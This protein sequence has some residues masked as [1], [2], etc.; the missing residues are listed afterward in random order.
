M[1][2]ND[3]KKFSKKPKLTLEAASHKRQHAQEKLPLGKQLGLGGGKQVTCT[4]GILTA[5][6]AGEPSVNKSAK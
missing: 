3:F 2:D 4:R 6:L 1:R 5:P